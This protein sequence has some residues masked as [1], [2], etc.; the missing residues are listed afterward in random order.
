VAMCLAAG[1]M[2]LVLALVASIVPA[3]R[4]LRLDPIAALRA[5]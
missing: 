4:A 3:R 5:P 1:G 2:L